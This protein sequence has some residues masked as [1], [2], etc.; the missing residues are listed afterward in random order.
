MFQL[1]NKPEPIVKPVDVPTSNTAASNHTTTKTAQSGGKANKK[2][3][4][5]R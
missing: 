2:K 3:G 5:K 1:M 4:K